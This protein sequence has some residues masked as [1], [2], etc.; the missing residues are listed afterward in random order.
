[1]N[2]V[3]MFLFHRI[4]F[5]VG[6]LFRNRKPQAEIKH[7][8]LDID[9]FKQLG[10]E[11][12]LHP[13]D[14]RAMNVLTGTDVF[15]ML[16]RHSKKSYKHFSPDLGLILFICSLHASFTKH[17]LRIPIFGYRTGMPVYHS[18]WIWAGSLGGPVFKRR[19]LEATHWTD[20]LNRT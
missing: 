17:F 8:K 15:S 10:R 12:T 13:I 19:F 11:W 1:M 7:L 5:L 18:S 4:Q 6:L 3:N 2:T 16:L 9:H 14:P 20:T